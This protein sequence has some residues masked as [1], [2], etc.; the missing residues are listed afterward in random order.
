LLGRQTINGNR[1]LLCQQTCPSM[2]NQGL[3]NYKWSCRMQSQSF[4]IWT[5][6]SPEQIW[7]VNRKTNGE[8]VNVSF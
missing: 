5:F 4:L 2:L 8:E 6:R 7:Y 3:A 1:R